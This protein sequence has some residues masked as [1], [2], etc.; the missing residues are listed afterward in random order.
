M[1]YS[2]S[3]FVYIIS[4]DVLGFIDYFVLF[5]WLQETSKKR[6][7]AALAEFQTN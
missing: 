5:I 7:D 1:L 3:P 6:Q 4:F 2:L